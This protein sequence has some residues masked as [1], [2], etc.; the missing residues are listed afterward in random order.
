MNLWWI[1]LDY[2]FHGAGGGHTEWVYWGQQKPSGDNAS[3]IAREKADLICG[4]GGW[5]CT[6]SIVPHNAVPDEAV[7]TKIRE[8]TSIIRNA[9]NELDALTHC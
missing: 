5:T 7:K 9:E 2:R 6:E 3:E 1:K 8:L 4:P